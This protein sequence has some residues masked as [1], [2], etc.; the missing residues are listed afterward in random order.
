MGLERRRRVRSRQGFTLVELM[1]VIIII[2]VV[3]ALAAGAALRIAASQRLSNSRQTVDKVARSLQRQWTAVI[4]NA[5][6]DTMPSGVLDW[7]QNDPERARVMW[8]KLKL[9]TEFPTSFQEVFT[10]QP[11]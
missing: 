10:D 7:A 1:V 3:G 5:L 6:Q 4:D 8:V 9:A 2:L 11:T